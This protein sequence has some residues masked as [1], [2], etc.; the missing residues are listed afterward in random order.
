MALSLEIPDF[1]SHLKVDKR[2]YPIPFFITPVKEGDPDFRFIHPERIQMIVE[3][4][5]CHICGKK[6]SKDYF[7]FIS[8]PIG[9]KNR[10]SS[11][12]AMHRSCAE[13][14]LFSCPHLFF[15]KAS[16][17]QNDEAGSKL[18][19]ASINTF[20]K[21]EK[22]SEIILIKADKCTFVIEKNTKA[23][24]IRYRPVSME[25]YIYVDGRLQKA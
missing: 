4:K 21:L 3:R 11:D 2:G 15:E 13:F 9:L 6:L 24:I 8:G 5:L 23:P 25:T 7:Y 14:S 1:L 19:A 18:A 17:R 10:A 12:A 20:H 16:Y 22:P